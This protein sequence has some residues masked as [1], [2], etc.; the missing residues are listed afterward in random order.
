MPSRPDRRNASRAGP[1]RFGPFELDAASG[2]LYRGQ[3]E[4]L[5]P[6]RAAGVLAVLIRRPG[7][8]LTKN[9]LLGEV[10]KDA[11]VGEDSLTQAIS[12]VRG[13]LGDDPHVAATR[14]DRLEAAVLQDPKKLDGRDGR[15]VGCH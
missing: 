15:K 2:L 13:A 14:P 11:F 3:Q 9:D 5:L 7:E 6:P 1:V 8:V 12:M 4:I 10:W